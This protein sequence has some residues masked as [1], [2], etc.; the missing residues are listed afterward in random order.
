MSFKKTKCK[1]LHFSHNNPMHPCRLGAEWL[2]SCTEEKDVRVL[3][4]HQLNKSQQC[5]QV[6][7]KA[8][9]I[10]AYIRNSVIRRIR[11]VI[12]PLYLALVRL[13]LEFQ[14]PVL[15]RSFQERHR[16]PEACP[17]KGSETGEGSGAQ[18]SWGVAE[19]TGIV[20]SGGSREISLSTTL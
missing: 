18:V 8:N 17:E 14:R 13:H 12:I 1:V 4:D 16:G 9:G 5:A 3:V 10:L 20:E 11:E 15:G 19:V 2:E 6:A 7:K